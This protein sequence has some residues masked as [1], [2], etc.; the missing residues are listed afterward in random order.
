MSILDTNEN[1]GAESQLQR[2]RLR[3]AEHLA[4]PT[5]EPEDAP[6][7]APWLEQ[8]RAARH[9]SAEELAAHL[10]TDADGLARLSLC[11]APREDRFREDVATLAAYI[12]CPLAPLRSLLRERQVMQGFTETSGMVSGS[13]SVSNVTGMPVGL[14]VAARD[15]NDMEEPDD[16][17][18]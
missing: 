7:L 14:M 2:M 18:Q 6:F 16:H 1:S 15:R 17:D 11:L 4:Q 5:G 12:G 8:Y 10:G 13:A 3:L 9:W